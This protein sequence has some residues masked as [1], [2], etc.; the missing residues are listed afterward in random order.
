MTTSQFT[1]NCRAFNV[2]HIS[3]FC[4]VWSIIIYIITINQYM[5]W[6]HK[7]T[8]LDINF[9]NKFWLDGPLLAK[10]TMEEWKLQSRFDL[11]CTSTVIKGAILST[12]PSTGLSGI[13]FLYSP[14]YIW[15]FRKTNKLM[16]NCTKDEVGCDFL[17]PPHNHLTPATVPILNRF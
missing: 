6:I 3:R 8:R 4:F 7:I 12:P 13:H 11:D 16:V 9:S 1:K 14:N 10:N 17:R 5:I 15:W 2:L